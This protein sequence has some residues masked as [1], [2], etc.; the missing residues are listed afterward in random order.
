MLFGFDRLNLDT[1]VTALKPTL[2]KNYAELD[3]VFS[4]N[5]DCDYDYN[6]AG[7]TRTSFCHL[8]LSWIQYCLSKREKV[9]RIILVLI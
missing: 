3:P 9:C 8:Y 4:A 2:D 6:I 1:I 7:V 5:I